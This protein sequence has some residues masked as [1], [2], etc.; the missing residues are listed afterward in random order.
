MHALSFCTGYSPWLRYGNTVS[1]NTRE[2]IRK[3]CVCIINEYY[4]CNKISC[5]WYGGLWG[6]ML[7]RLVQKLSSMWNLSRTW[8]QS[9]KDNF[10]LWV[11][12]LERCCLRDECCLRR[13][14]LPSFYK[15]WHHIHPMCFFYILTY[16]SI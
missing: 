9:F 14:F 8:K 3:L 1:G 15:K 12:K 11:V 2:W 7:V 6:H 4:G 10:R 5:L 16:Y 13:D